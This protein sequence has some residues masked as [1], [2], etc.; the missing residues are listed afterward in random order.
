MIAHV[1]QKIL[2][3]L[4]LSNKY[5]AWRIVDAWLEKND[6]YLIPEEDYS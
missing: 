4:V 1:I 6:F 5:L 2:I 3:K